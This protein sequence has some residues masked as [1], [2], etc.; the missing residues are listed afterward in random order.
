MTIRP[1]TLPDRENP[2]PLSEM[3]HVTGPGAEPLVAL[4]VTGG[5]PSNVMFRSNALG[6]KIPVPPESNVR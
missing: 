4:T 3:E 1:V 6:T 5:W 2:G